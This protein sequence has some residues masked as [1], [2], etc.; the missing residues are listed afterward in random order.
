M[1]KQ[2][3]EKIVREILTQQSNEAENKSARD[4]NVTFKQTREQIVR[5]ILA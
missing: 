5:E 2:T 4:P 3:K 1:V